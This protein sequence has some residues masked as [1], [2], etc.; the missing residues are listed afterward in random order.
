M[1]L[2]TAA[3]GLLVLLVGCGSASPAQ[4]TSA[5]VTTQATA[6][7]SPSPSTNPAAAKAARKAARRLAEQ[8]ARRRARREARRDARQR[9][10]AA[11]AV[12]CTASMSNISPGDYAT[13]DVLVQTSPGAAV[14]ATAHYKTEDTTNEGFADGS[15]AASIP[16][17]TSGATL[18]YTVGVDVTATLNGHSGSCSTSFTP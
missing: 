17:Y 18:G 14:T 13:T 12:H 9:A 1:K 7:P 5:P 6:S 15:G 16:F 3:A 2:A 8:E 10:A 11:A 4:P